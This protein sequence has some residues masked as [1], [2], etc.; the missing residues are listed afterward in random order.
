MQM[1]GVSTTLD[2]LAA[3][4]G[5]LRRLARSLVQ[6]PA[7]ADDLVQDAYLLAA[8]QPPGDDRPLRPWLVRV[9]RNLTRTKERVA[10]RRSER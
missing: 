7:A 3:D 6:N 10:S 1:P 4:A 5:W 9:L 8:E 2:Q